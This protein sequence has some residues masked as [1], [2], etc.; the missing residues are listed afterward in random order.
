M[1]LR[2]KNEIINHAAHSGWGGFN[3][4]KTLS[5]NLVLA[6]DFPN[7][8][9]FHFLWVKIFAEKSPKILKWPEMCL[10]GQIL[11]QDFE[12]P[13]VLKIFERRD[14]SIAPLLFLEDEYKTGQTQTHT[15]LTTVTAMRRSPQ[16]LPL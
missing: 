1:A 7:K 4:N 5:K 16:L 6:Q 9:P 8:I 12:M 11:A 2:H 14:L 13:A 10:L 15:A 3:G